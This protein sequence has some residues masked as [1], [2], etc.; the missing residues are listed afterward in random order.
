[1]SVKVVVKSSLNKGK[2]LKIAKCDRYLNK[3]D[4]EI[5]ITVGDNGTFELFLEPNSNSDCYVAF[6]NDIKKPFWIYEDFEGKEQNIDL[7]KEI[8]QREK[9]DTYLESN[10]SVFI[11]NAKRVINKVVCDYPI[12]SKEENR[13]LCRYDKFYQGVTDNKMC[14]LDKGLSNG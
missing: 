8:L 13:L 10:E 9:L 3:I 5:S 4:S 2:Q 12:V 14:K 7:T 11:A 1:M 6:E